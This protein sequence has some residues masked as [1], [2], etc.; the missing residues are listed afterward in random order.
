LVPLGKLLIYNHKVIITHSK[1]ASRTFD[2]YTNP[3]KEILFYSSVDVINKLKI[4]SET[5][6]IYCLNRN[7]I[8][9]I[10]SGLWNLIESTYLARTENNFWLQ[11]FIKDYEKNNE[12]IEL[13][14][15]L[16]LTIEPDNPENNIGE[17][18]I[19]NTISSKELLK[20]LNLHIYLYNNKTTWFENEFKTN[21]HLFANQNLIFEIQK[22]ID[23]EVVDIEK[24]NNLLSYLN[25][26]FSDEKNEEI[27]TKYSQKAP[28]EFYSIFLEY[29]LNRDV[30][31][32]KEHFEKIYNKSDV[33]D[34][35]S[36]YSIKENLEI[37][38]LINKEIEIYN[39]IGDR[40]WQ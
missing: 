21:P 20:I 34:I 22:N 23:C 7:P 1:R 37:I 3:I 26:N 24:K 14:K 36:V 2:N 17:K 18:N 15:L 38:H 13:S 12:P 5:K 40:L 25:F 11:E 6:K 19:Y 31:T 16:H 4:Y 35:K 27:K 10:K 33:V 39:K 30:K 32:I 28:K 9:H 8:T 29:I